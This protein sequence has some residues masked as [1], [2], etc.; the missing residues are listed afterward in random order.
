MDFAKLAARQD[1]FI[2]EFASLFERKQAD[3]PVA[4]LSRPLE[5]R[6]ARAAAI[7][8]RIE[9]IEVATTEQVRQ[10]E[11]EIEALHGELAMLEIAQNRDAE[12]IEPVAK[13]AKADAPKRGKRG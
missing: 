2:E 6:E 8:A 1:A 5:A 10:A 9:A 13:A 11:A 7:K 4:M 3:V 12:L